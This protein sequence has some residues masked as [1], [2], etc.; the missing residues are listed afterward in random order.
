MLFDYEQLISYLQKLE[1]S[2]PRLELIETGKSPLGKN[3]YIAFISSGENISKL[4]QLK[5]I[6]RRL[7]LDPDIP[8]SERATM[9]ENGRVFALAT[10][11]M[12]SGEVGPSQ[13]APLVAYDLVTTEDREVLNWLEDV[14]Y[15]MV[16][17]HNPDGMDLVV[18]HYKR[19]KGTVYEGSSLPGIYHKYVGHDNNR[20]FIILSQEDTRAIA[21]IY[22]TEWFPQVMVEKHQMGSTGPRY[23]VPPPHDPI[24]ENLDEGIWNWVGIFG[25]NMAKDLT[26]KGLAGVSQH[27]LFDEYWPGP[28]GTSLWKNVITFLTEAASVRYAKPIFIE[29]NELRVYGK[30]LSEYKKGIN[31]PL[32]WPGGWWRLSD[33]LEYETTSVMSLIRTASLHRKD[34]LRFRNDLCRK[35]VSKGRSTPPFYYVLPLEQSDQS[36]LVSLVALLREHGIS[37]YSLSS[38]ITINGMNLS[39]G[40]IV[41]PLSQPF[42]PFIMEVMERQ[43]FPVRHYTAG[44]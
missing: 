37:I 29:P 41:I 27:Y 11:S 34:I 31:M 22:N 6:N 33:I 19:Y 40:D 14:V 32:P 36:E 24:A 42:R 8:E 4:Q 12:H 7:A 38:A 30:G 28:T 44:G 25:S 23:F 10:L 17:C 15:M 21:R 2:S 18:E 16:P 35:E 43:T 9:L 3:M 26:G 39:E 20:D 13:A 5:E 1:S